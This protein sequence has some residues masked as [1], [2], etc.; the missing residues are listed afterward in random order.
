MP[1]PVLLFLCFFCGLLLGS[2]PVFIVLLRRARETSTTGALHER[3]AGREARNVELEKNL[4]VLEQ[5]LTAES[6]LLRTESAARASAENEATRVA[7]LE[8]DLAALREEKE[9]LAAAHSQLQTSLQNE[10]ENSAE[11]LSLLT[12]AKNALTLQ[13]KALADEVLQTK[14]EQFTQQHQQATEQNRTNL[15]DLLSP[16][17]DQLGDF[18]KKVEEVYV[19]EGK[20]RSA[21]KAEVEQ[22]RALNVS[23]GEEARNLTTALKGSNKTQGNYGELVLERVLEASGLRKGC[24][25]EVQ[26]SHSVE[27]K[28]QQPDVIITLPEGRRLVVDS[29]MSLA[30]YETSLSA[31]DAPQREAAIKAHIA[32][33]RGHINGLS[34]KNYQHLYGIQSLDFV[35]L[36]VPLEP[37]FLLAVTSDN[38]LYMEAWSRNVLLVSPSTLLFVVR[39]VA[40]LWRQEA[41]TRNAQDIAKRG[42]EL[43]DKFTSF[44]KDLESLGNRIGQAKEDYDQALAK[45]ASGRGNL[46]RQAELLRDLGI[47]PSKSLPENLLERSRDELP[48]LPEHS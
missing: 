1:P 11:K 42:A 36:F 22:L 48:A 10:R 19:Q 23:L 5:R 39:T 17:K 16:L 37:A 7:G 9:R 44:V 46:I 30:A 29:K 8:A 3:L 6:A 47:K 41:Q 24:E 2:V 21:L 14:V 33:L 25:Y 28:R 38:S 31:G 43:Y 40:H 4:S 26:V 13:F 27:G 20:D 15:G 35:I 45:L 32:S 12:E 18:K 34:A